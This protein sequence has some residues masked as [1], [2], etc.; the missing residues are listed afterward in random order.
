ME[1]GEKLFIDLLPECWR[2]LPPSLPTEVIEELSR[3][4]KEAEERARQLARRKASEEPRD[5]PFRVGT[6]PTFS[7]LVFEM[8]VTAPVDVPT[9][10]TCT[11]SSGRLDA[12]SRTVP[13]ADRGP[14]TKR[15][16]DHGPET[17]SASQQKDPT[18][19]RAA[20]VCGD[21]VSGLAFAFVLSCMHLW[22]RAG[23]ACEVPGF[24]TRQYYYELRRYCIQN[25]PAGLATP[26]ML[27]CYS[28][29]DRVAQAFMIK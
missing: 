11:A 20:L 18:T 2:G 15:T 10:N 23:D 26:S 22:W 8:P 25:C 24:A 16:T 5:M 19:A 1:A 17:N 7:R 6:T 28:L 29:C 21:R 9:T 13:M 4:A 12:A 14:R 27:S 3:R